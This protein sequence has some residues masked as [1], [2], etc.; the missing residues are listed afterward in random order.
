[1][2]L[3]FEKQ[4]TCSCLFRLVAVGSGLFQILRKK[5]KARKARQKLET[6]KK[7]KARKARM[8]VKR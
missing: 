6:F 7:V 5:V 4:I 1:M 2:Y 8:Y 3:Y